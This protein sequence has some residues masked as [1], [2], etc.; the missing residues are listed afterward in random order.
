MAASSISPESC[1]MALVPLLEAN[2]MNLM[3][4]QITHIAMADHSEPVVETSKKLNVDVFIKEKNI[5]EKH[6]AGI[7]YGKK[8]NDP[9]AFANLDLLFLETA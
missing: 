2:G 6:S 8:A 4:P 7:K 3:P 5:V 9:T 1:N